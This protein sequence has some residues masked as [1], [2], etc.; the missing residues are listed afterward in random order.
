MT[1]IKNK[2]P[3]MHRLPRVGDKVAP[4]GKGGQPGYPNGTIGKVVEIIRGACGP[5]VCVEFGNYGKVDLFWKK[6]TIIKE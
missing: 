3:R 6:I 2:R 4:I 5:I 1:I